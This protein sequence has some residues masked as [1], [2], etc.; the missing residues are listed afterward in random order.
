M[1]GGHGMSIRAA[2]GCSGIKV[3]RALAHTEGNLI[4]LTGVASQ[5]QTWTCVPSNQLRRW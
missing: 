2:A 4:G 5:E 3:E 1:K